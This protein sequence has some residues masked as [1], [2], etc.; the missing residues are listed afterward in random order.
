[1]AC[2]L[3]VAANSVMM[4]EI[5][6]LRSTNFPSTMTATKKSPHPNPTSAISVIGSMACTHLP[7]SAMKTVIIAGYQWSKW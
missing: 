2:S 7:V 3:I 6:K 1:M 4:T 5:K